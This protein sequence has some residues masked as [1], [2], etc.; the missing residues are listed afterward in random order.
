MIHPNCFILNYF[1]KK[2][3]KNFRYQKILEGK[4]ELPT[5]ISK[6][7]R[8]LISKILVVNPENR[9]QID[10]IRKHP[11]YSLSSKDEQIYEIVNNQ[12]NLIF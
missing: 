8:D 7:V 12:V 4:Y 10:E 3:N 6:K 2:K 1:F 9:I 5:F 11:W